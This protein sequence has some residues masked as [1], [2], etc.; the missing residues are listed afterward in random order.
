[1]ADTFGNPTYAN[2]F[3]PFSPVRLFSPIGSNR[4]ET[5]FFVPGTAGATPAA[6]RGFGLIL[7][8]V[9]LPNGTDQ[10]KPSSKVEY[11]DTDGRLLF[12]SFAPASPGDGGLTFFGIVLHDARIARV[13]ITAGN[14]EPG[15]DD[16]RKTDIVV[17]DDFIFGE[18]QPESDTCPTAYV[19]GIGSD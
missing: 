18:P 4:T 16:T 10:Q 5:L 19:A 1:L 13:L 12:S 2:I 9:D 6:T 17:M 3:Q 14:S 11:F 15:P 8:D 7:A